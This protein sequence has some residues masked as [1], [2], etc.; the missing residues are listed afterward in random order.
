MVILEARKLVQVN[1]TQSNS[2]FT[3]KWKDD[4]NKEKTF[5]YRGKSEPF[6][7]FLQKLQVKDNAT[8]PKSARGKK[9]REIVAEII[10]DSDN[11]IWIW[12]PYLKNLANK[13]INV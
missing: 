7:K 2:F 11:I 1:V 8:E 6:T 9:Y 12:S 3:M 4:E 13:S 10:D 5:V